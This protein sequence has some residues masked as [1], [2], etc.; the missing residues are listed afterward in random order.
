MDE[1]TCPFCKSD[2]RGEE[3]P[4]EYRDKY[5]GGKTHYSRLIGIEDSDKYDGVSYWN[6]PDC[7]TTWDRFTGKVEEEN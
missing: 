4:E 7:N 5:Y 3:I 2:L 6:C 1:Y